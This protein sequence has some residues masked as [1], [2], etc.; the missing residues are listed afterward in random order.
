MTRR[1]RTVLL[2]ATLGA[3]SLMG[4]LHCSSL[5][6]T[7]AAN[8]STTDANI[9]RL[10][11]NI[12]EQ[13]QFAHHAFD[14]ELAGRFLDSYLDALDGTRS[15]FLKSDADEFAA[16]RATLVKATREAGDTTAAHIIFRRYLERLEQRNAFVANALKGAPFEYTGQ[17]VY[18][19]DREHAERPLDLAAANELWR[20][21][22]RAEYLQE[23]LGD[24]PADKIATRLTRRA[25]Q[26]LTMMK[27]LRS[28]EV[29]EIYLNALAHVYDPHSDYLGHEQM[30]SLTISMN[31]SLFGIGASLESADGYCTIRQVLPGGPAARSGVLKSGD[32]IVTVAQAN[33][34]PD[35]VV[36][37]PLSRIVQLIRG[38]KGSTV[39][40]GIIPAGAPDGS[41]PKIVQMVR[42]EIRLEDQEAK[43]RIFDSQ[44]PNGATLRLG[45][46]DVPEFYADMGDRKKGESRSVTT[47]VARLV[48][49]LKAEKVQGIA[50]DLRR[51][52]GGSLSEA[53]SLTGLFIKKGPVVQTR[54]ATG[55]VDVEQDPDSSVLFDGPLIVL[56]S[57]FSASASEI[58][59]GA[60]QDYGRAVIVGDSQTFGKG[61]VQSILPLAQIMDKNGLGHA[62]DPGA[63]KVTIRKFYRP[64][65]AST[66]LRGVRSDVVLPSISDFSAVSESALKDPLPWDA[67]S[68]APYARLNRV[69]PYLAALREK[70][71][72]RVA[73]EKA[74]AD[75]KDEIARVQTSITSKSVSLNEADRRQ[76]LAQ[77][78]TR[79]TER[80]QEIAKVRAA[81]P[82]SYAITLKN[83][84]SPGLPQASSLDE[85]PGAAK[86]A[87]AQPQDGTSPVGMADDLVLSESVR[88]LADYTDLS[89]G[90]KLTPAPSVN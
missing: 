17:E 8:R 86:E 1:R 3:V 62:Y 69:S 60:L 66:Q 79:Q 29:L 40:L 2:L 90:T 33:K 14:D 32:R 64:G 74:F 83:A 28:N 15:L 4:A 19:P 63:L 76:E 54:G 78:K 41:P 49:K 87:A 82:K 16:F 48:T 58:L 81:Q 36:N 9:V 6:A 22:L 56:T 43:A 57:R 30:E 55:D 7:P 75:L 70:S 25:S 44:R 39:R 53:I 23:K 37:M 10:T 35:D 46:I 27:T 34:D 13:S 59:A 61:T 38:P 52:G 5:S 88:V 42:D 26:Q 68:A 20:Q 45:V 77:T 65:G 24:A 21:Q 72:G 84:S 18:S 80:E 31:L 51:N 89:R 12:L 71:A 47:D 67:V 85:V 11:T 73:T 50:L